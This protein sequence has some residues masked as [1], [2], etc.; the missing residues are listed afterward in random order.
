MH[1]DLRETTPT[2]ASFAASAPA[3]CGELVQGP[4][5]GRLLQITCPIDLRSVAAARLSVRQ[6]P[7]EGERRPWPEISWKDSEPAIPGAFAKAR[8]GALEA[9]R[10]CA[11]RSA[12]PERGPVE[13]GLHSPAPRGK[14][15]GSSSA[16]VLA[17]ATAVSRALGHD[18]SPHDL[19]ALALSVEP[20]DGTMLPGLA[21]F[22]H[23]EGRVREPLGPAPPMRILVVDAGGTVDTVAFN[24][25]RRRWSA[26]AV[27]G[28]ERAFR[29]VI[30]GVRSGDLEAVGRG[31]TLSASLNQRAIPK[32]HLS[33]LARLA[34]EGGGVGVNA[35]H[36]GT[37]VGIL[38]PD[39]PGPVALA[40]ER[41]RHRFPGL[42]CVGSHRIVEGGVRV[43]PSAIGEAF[44]AAIARKGGIR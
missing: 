3:T 29:L 7:S 17:T 8:R 12:S 15:M 32:P 24:A 43:E 31:A 20:T 22:D 34:R 33:E 6:L 38:F 23:R 10:R 42:R 5:G 9:V 11:G 35:A 37:V 2:P 40:G 4:F 16:D 30:R 25:A 36:S 21:L 44:P 14:G 1:P 28:W 26:R 18:P 13:V 39:E 27:R 19:A 41:I